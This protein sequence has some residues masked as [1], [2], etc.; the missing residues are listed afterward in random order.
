MPRPMP[1]PAP[2]TIATFPASMSTIVPSSRVV[3]PLDL[4]RSI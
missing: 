1:W 2:V 3:Q 4:R